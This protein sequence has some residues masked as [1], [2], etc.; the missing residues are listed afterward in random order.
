MKTSIF[1]AFTYYCKS[2]D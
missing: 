1:I 2:R